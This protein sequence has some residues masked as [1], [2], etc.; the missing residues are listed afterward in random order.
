M[1]LEGLERDNRA[2]GGIENNEEL[3]LKIAEGDNGCSGR[4]LDSTMKALEISQ[5][6]EKLRE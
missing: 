5:L 4:V 3:R 6:N 2:Q 1:G